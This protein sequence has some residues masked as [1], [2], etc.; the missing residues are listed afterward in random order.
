MALSARGVP[1]EYSSKREVCKQT[2]RKHG[3]HVPHYNIHGH[4][5]HRLPLKDKTAFISVKEHLEWSNVPKHATKAELSRARRAEKY[6]DM[7]Y[8]LDGDGVV[9]QRDYFIGKAFDRDQDNRLN[10]AERSEAMHALQNG[11]LDQYSFGHDQAGAKRPFPVLQKRGKILTVD[12]VDA[13]WSTFPKHWNA[14]K[15]PHFATKTEMDI[16]RRAFLANAANAQKEAW[17][18]QNPF[19][20]PEPPVCQEFYVENPTITHISQ[21]A[22]AEHQASRVAAGLLPTNTFV[23]PHRESRSIGLGKVENP[24]SGTW[25]DLKERRKAEMKMELE[26]QRL[27]GEKYHVPYIVRQTARENAAYEFRRGGNSKAS[28]HTKL[29]HERKQDKIE[30]EMATFESPHRKQYPRHSDQRQPWWSPRSARCGPT[31][32]RG[33]TAPPALERGRHHREDTHVRRHDQPHIYARIPTAC[34]TSTR[35]GPSHIGS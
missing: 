27:R 26:E 7:S 34:S 35:R 16:S 9:G 5:H 20:V 10:T 12:N 14:D 28:T 32:S 8:D 18:L 21:R 2:I 1:G 24:T 31:H 4:Q 13:L 11:W 30:R 3:G 25:T 19:F 6:P 23:N 29:K 17:D 22:E 15:V 33:S